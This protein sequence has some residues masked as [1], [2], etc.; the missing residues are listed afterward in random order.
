[1]IGSSGIKEGNRNMTVTVELPDSLYDQAKARAA[2]Q[3]TTVDAFFVNAII[4]KLGKEKDRSKRGLMAVSGKGDQE[5]VAEVQRI[6]D[7]ESS[8]RYPQP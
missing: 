7:E 2:V 5:A 4:A 8:P 3:G 1:M 6:I